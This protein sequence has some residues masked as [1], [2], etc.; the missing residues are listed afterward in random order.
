MLTFPE[1][2]SSTLPQQVLWKH[3]QTAAEVLFH[4]ALPIFALKIHW[5]EPSHRKIPVT[6][7]EN[8]FLLRVVRELCS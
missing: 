5:E 6:K 2:R 1:G 8:G 3:V 7:S 4:S